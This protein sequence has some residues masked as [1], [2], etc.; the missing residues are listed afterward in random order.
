MDDLDRHIINR[1]QDGFPVCKQP[2]AEIGGEL[3]LDENALIKRIETLLE[4]GMLSRFGPMYN[5][6]RLGGVY[7]L[8]AMKVPL[9]IFE[10]T[11]AYINAFAEVAHNYERE[12]EFNMWFVLAADTSGTMQRVIDEI[13]NHTGLQVYNMPKLKEYFVGLKFHV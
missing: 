5:M 13:E 12:H 10:E 4:N 6:E 9:E 3:N 8:A 1:L 2:F 11:A 7:S